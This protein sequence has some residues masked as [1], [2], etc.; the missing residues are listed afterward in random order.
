MAERVR[1]TEKALTAFKKLPQE[2][3]ENYG[4]CIKSL[5]RRFDPDSKR[6]LYVD[7]LSTRTRRRDELRPAIALSGCLRETTSEPKLA[8]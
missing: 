7:E 8:F 1:L 4:E 2:V 6:Q 3:K 5:Q